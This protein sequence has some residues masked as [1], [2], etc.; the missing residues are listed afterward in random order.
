MA[1]LSTRFIL[2]LASQAFLIVF[3]AFLYFLYWRE[4]KQF[5]K[6]VKS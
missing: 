3:M 6:E 4:K 2:W 1:E 5:E